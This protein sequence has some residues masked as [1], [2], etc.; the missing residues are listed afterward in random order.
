MSILL[1]R[2]IPP[3][4][5]ATRLDDIEKHPDRRFVI[6]GKQRLNA[7]TSFRKDEFPIELEGKLFTL[8]Q[9]KEETPDYYKAIAHFYI[10]S[11]VAYDLSDKQMIE[12]FLC[13]NF[14]GTP[15]D[16]THKNSLVSSLSNA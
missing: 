3:I 4:A 7:L 14:S 10:E 9:L 12:W 8:T 16:E 11:A 5:L 1:E 15:A 2:Y 13:I 6:D